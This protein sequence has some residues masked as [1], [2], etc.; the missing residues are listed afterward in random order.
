MLMRRHSATHRVEGSRQSRE[1]SV[2]TNGSPEAS[3][4]ISGPKSL[5][6]PSLNATHPHPP[7][8]PAQPVP[9]IQGLIPSP[10]LFSLF[11]PAAPLHALAAAA[12][13]PCTCVGRCRGLT[14]PCHPRTHADC[15]HALQLALFGR[16]GSRSRPRMHRLPPHAPACTAR[17]PPPPPL[18]PS[19][20]LPLTTY[21]VPTA[22]G[23][24]G[25]KE[26]RTRKGPCRRRQPRRRRVQVLQ[27]AAR[28]DR[29][30][31]FCRYGCGGF[32]NPDRSIPL[33]VFFC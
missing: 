32:H 22:Q 30:T 24:T 26:V 10:T 7:P 9:Y 25:V 29:G 11:L 27:G 23:P 15:H 33:F 4:H 16:A 19:S 14:R 2:A 8:S 13:R 18:S 12:A 5:D 3:T 21:A 28:Y 1:T 6:P 20:P 17:S 31:C